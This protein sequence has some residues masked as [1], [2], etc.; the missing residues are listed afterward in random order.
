ML[1]R[2]SLP[3]PMRRHDLH[4]HSTFSDGLLPPAAVVARAAARGVD[5]LALTD[6]DEVGGLADAREAASEAGI[7]LVCGS[8]LSVTWEGI[9]LHIVALQIDPRNSTLTEGLEAIRSG[10]L[11][12]ARR[13]A[14]ALAV[15]GIAGAYEGALKYVTSERLISR[16]HFAR[17][18]V[19]AGYARAMKD[20]FK[21][22]LTRGN[23]GYVAHQWATLSQAVGWIH[24]AG[25][26]AVVAHPGRYGINASEMRRLLAEFRDIGGD[27]IEVLSPS[28]TPSQYVEFATHA[29][30]FGLRA[31]CGSDWHGPGEGWMDFGELPEMPS[32]IVPVWKDW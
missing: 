32:G 17:H 7:T 29:R 23:P 30:V 5:V 28:H 10:R 13:I 8:E 22:Y 3:A 4:C 24:A 2:F 1:S 18:L 26:R 20:V 16:T 25:G 27:A 11:T 15:A 14:D 6:H 12:R 21:R 9:T 19:E 31:S